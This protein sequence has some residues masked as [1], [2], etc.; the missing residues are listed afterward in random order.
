MR[1]SREQRAWY[2]YDWANSGYITTTTTVF[3]GPYLTSVAKRAAGCTS[4]G[5]CSTNLHLLGLPIA[6]GSVFF[7]AVTFV[8]LLSALLL[9]VV[10]AYTD[11]RGDKRRLLGFFAWAGSLAAAS[12]FFVSGTNWLLG[13]ALLL[14]ANLCMGASLVVYDAILIDIA[15]PSDRDRVSSRGW[16]FGYIGGGL[17][18]VANLIMYLTPGTFGIDEAMAVRISLC[19][20]GVWWA[21]WTVIPFLR[22]VDRPPHVGLPAELDRTLVKGSFTQLRSTLQHMRNYP[23]TLL[24]LVA[25]LFYNDGVQTVISSASVYGAEQLELGQS[26]LIGAIVLVQFVAFGGA[27]VFGRLAARIGAF[28]VVYGSLLV[29]ILA[30][31][32]GYFLPVGAAGAFFGLAALLGITLGGTQALSRSL[33]SQLIPRGKE[34]EYFS[35]YQATER[36]TS[37]LGTLIFGLVHQITDSYRPAIVSL[38]LFF[39]LGGLVLRKVD[40]ARGITDAGNELPAVY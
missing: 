17:L 34:A 12:M 36:G 28:R 4:E 14:V 38:I 25:Y 39:V 19:I 9:P 11:R 33:F 7:Y 32:S 35:L 24:F 26:V 5:L 21:A 2:Y 10:G 16:A 15:T 22:I 20:A 18:L 31:G 1:S 37:W 6:P 13:V 29:W 27:L 40:I 8:T 30:V 23:H 3:F